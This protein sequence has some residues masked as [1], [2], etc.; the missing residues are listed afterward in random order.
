MMS[1]TVWL[2]SK[3]ISITCVQVS[4][5]YIYVEKTE[6]LYICLVEYNLNSAT[7]SAIQVM[8]DIQST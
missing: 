3:N 1:K 4:R 5:E 6:Q 2:L 8:I 7:N